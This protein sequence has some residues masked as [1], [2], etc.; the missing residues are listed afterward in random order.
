MRPAVADEG[1]HLGDIP[2]PEHPLLAQAGEADAVGVGQCRPEH[3]DAEV[4]PRVDV[5]APL[6][7]PG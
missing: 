6:C 5:A 1:A 4:S 3:L 7:Q 2:P